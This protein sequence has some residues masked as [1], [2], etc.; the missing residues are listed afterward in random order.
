M[1]LEADYNTLKG[2]LDAMNEAIKLGEMSDGHHSFNE[3]YEYR[4]LYNVHTALAFNHAGWNVVRSWKHADGKECFDGG[5]FVVHAETPAG[6]ITNHY[7]AA[8]WRYFDGIA[9]AP[10]APEWDGHT[11]EVAKL[12][13][14]AAIEFLRQRFVEMG[15]YTDLVKRAYAR[16]CGE[17]DKY[18]RRT[19]EWR[20]AAMNDG[21]R[22]DAEWLAAEVGREHIKRCEIEQCD[23]CS[24]VL[25]I[26][27]RL[28]D[29]SEE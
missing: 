11:P 5:W 14:E 15:N 17:R 9:D 6:Q 19:A 18:M 22:R 29:M 26:E 23:T 3:L 27:E 24:S 25:G 20:D 2:Q 10:T 13:L 1:S 28:K 21:F 16:V 7:K 8:Y 4:L 12:R